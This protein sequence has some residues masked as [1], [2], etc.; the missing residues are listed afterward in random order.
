MK[1]RDEIGNLAAAFGSMA[2]DLKGHQDKL[3]SYGRELEAMMT[4]LTRRN[5]EIT[6][7]SRSELTGYTHPAPRKA[8]SI[9]GML[10]HCPVRSLIG[11]HFR[12]SYE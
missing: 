1:S 8:L 4:E 3:L 9:Q 7:F 2:V 11:Y 10:T 5:Q 6:L 12:R